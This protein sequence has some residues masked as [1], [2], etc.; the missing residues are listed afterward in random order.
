MKKSIKDIDLT[1]KRVFLRADFNVPISSQHITD[2]YRILQ[3]LP[4]IDYILSQNIKSLIIASH[5]GRPDGVYDFQYSLEPV[6]LYL[7]KY[8][9]AKNLDLK[10]RAIYEDFDEK[11]VF[12]ENLRFCKEEIYDVNREKLEYYFESV[13]DLIVNDAFGIVHRETGCINRSKMPVFSGLLLQ[14]ELDFA[15]DLI[16]SEKDFDLIILGGKKVKDKI[17]LL[18]GFIKKAKNIYIC[19][20][21]CFIFLKVQGKRIGNFFCE[22]ELEKEAKE[23]LELAKNEGTKIHFPV[24]FV[25]I[26]KDEIKMFEDIED[27]FECFDIGNKSIYDLNKLVSESKKIFWNGPVGMFEAIEFSNGTKQLVESLCIATK[28]KS[29][30]IVGGGDT[31]SAVSKFGDRKLFT[32]VST[33]GGSLLS[34]I[35]G[36]ELPGIKVIEDIN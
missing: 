13:C 28:N 25:C 21:M 8:F 35:E 18:K 20:G 27:E 36:K 12:L 4:T 10:F 32:H 23:I 16:S 7:K 31:A 22:E 29:I 17:K 24:D 6:F 19:G 33:G 9:Q 30:T 14:K 15:S 1:D 2:D 5:L 3:T 26:K 11:F 34:L